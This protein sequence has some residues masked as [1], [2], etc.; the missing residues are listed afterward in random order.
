MRAVILLVLA[1]LL[2]C[3]PDEQPECKSDND[4]GDGC[5]ESKRC[6]EGQCQTRAGD[7][8]YWPIEPGGA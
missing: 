2:G 3:P 7:C 8:Q 1:F 4:C 6:K 5:Y